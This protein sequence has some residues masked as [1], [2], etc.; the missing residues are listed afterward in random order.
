MSALNLFV[1]TLPAIIPITTFMLYGASQTPQPIARRTWD[2]VS[3]L[4]IKIEGFV[5][6]TNTSSSSSSNK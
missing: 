3:I 2:K 6:G 1:A 4:N 5:I